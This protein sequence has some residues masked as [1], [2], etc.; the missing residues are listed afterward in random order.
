[1]SNEHQNLKAHLL[2]MLEAMS[3]KGP[4]QYLSNDRLRE[5]VEEQKIVFLNKMQ[6]E[7]DN[8]AQ[9]SVLNG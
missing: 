1:M 3:Y 5:L 8:N 4:V 6:R 9:G 7:L 2:M